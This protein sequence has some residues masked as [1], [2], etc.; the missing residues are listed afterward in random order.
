VTHE[1]GKVLKG[2]SDEHLAVILAVYDSDLV[3]IAGIGIASIP[4][5]LRYGGV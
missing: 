1:C 2:H 5:G 3:K 4:A